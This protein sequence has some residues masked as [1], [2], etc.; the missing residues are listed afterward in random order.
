MEEEWSSIR[1]KTLQADKLLTCHSC[2]YVFILR[3]LC[4]CVCVCVCACV[5]VCKKR[6]TRG[7][8][9]GEERLDQMQL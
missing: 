3:G 7:G 8:E 4:V 2:L 5:C 6:R 9:D 1:I